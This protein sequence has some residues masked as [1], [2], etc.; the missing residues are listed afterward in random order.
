[1][2]RICFLFLLSVGLVLSSCKNY[3]DRFDA[4]NG[5]I[6]ALQGQV[7]GLSALQTE[8]TALKSTITAIQSSLSGLQGTVTTV[9]SEVT[10]A[11]QTTQSEVTTAL[12]TAQTEITK[13]VGDQLNTGLSGLS[14]KNE[15]L[16]KSLAELLPKVTALETKL[17][18][19]QDG[20][21]SKDELTKLQT[22]LAEQYAVIKGQ[23]DESLRNS[24]F[25]NDSLIID[26]VGRLKFATNVLFENITEINGDVTIDTTEFWEVAGSTEEETNKRRQDLKDF[27][28][29][30]NL[31]YGT[32]DITHSSE[33]L[34]DAIKF[35]N[36]TLVTKLVDK[37]PHVHYP[38]LAS[39]NE[40]TFAEGDD[41]NTNADNVLTVQI[42]EITTAMFTA[43]TIH[44]K[45]GQKLHLNN[46]VSHKGN[47]SITLNGDGTTNLKSL[48]KLTGGGEATLKLTGF[49][50][51]D[52]PALTTLKK[53]HVKDVNSLTAVNVAGDADPNKNGTELRISEDVSRVDVGTKGAIANL[54][55]DDGE[56]ERDLEHLK[57]G[58]STSWLEVTI[59]SGVEVAHIHGAKIVKTD[60]S[61]DLDTFI[62]AREIKE[63]TL[64][65]TDI[66]TLELG[67]TS[68]S[69]GKLEIVNNESLESLTADKVN[70][71]KTLKIQG[72]TRLETISFTDDDGNGLVTAASDAVVHIGGVGN[73][74]R[75]RAS[76]IHLEVKTGAGKQDGKIVDESGLSD[77]K[78]FLGSS[79]I[80]TAEV[81]YDGTGELKEDKND[82]QNNV[83]ISADNIEDLVL[84]RKGVDPTEPKKPAVKAKRVWVVYG[85][86]D[87]A[88]PNNIR[89]NLTGGFYKDITILGGESSRNI[90]AKI[91]G[92]DLKKFFSQNDVTID[93][94][95][96]GFQPGGSI[97]F[98]PET[99]TAGFST[100]AITDALLGELEDGAYIKLGIGGTEAKPEYSHTVYIK[101]DK[102]TTKTFSATEKHAVSH[103]LLKTGNDDADGP[104]DVADNADDGA[105]INALDIINRLVYGFPG[106]PLGEDHPTATAATTS[107]TKRDVPLRTI[108]YQVTFDNTN[109]IV[110]LNVARYDPSPVSK[111]IPLYFDTNVDQENLV[112]IG[113]QQYSTSKLVNIVNIVNRDGL[114][115]VN[116]GTGNTL[117]ISLTSTKVGDGDD[118]NGKQSTIG[119][120][121]SFDADLTLI[122]HGQTLGNDAADPYSLGLFGNVGNRHVGTYTGDAGEPSPNVVFGDNSSQTFGAIEIAIKAEKTPGSDINRFYPYW[123]DP[124]DNKSETKLVPV[125]GVD[126]KDAVNVNTENVEERL[127]WL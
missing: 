14:E 40:I 84:F 76:A 124:K 80:K 16:S 96:S 48:K 97:A 13:N 11:L 65:G 112:G 51:V 127:G 103:L 34:E 77:L 94:T 86:G 8:V 88:A 1:M 93:A 4:L 3:D 120:P 19:I 26:S 32:L 85:I 22:D 122:Q 79:N 9:Q 53:L 62:T 28:K 37:Q 74:N 71:L 63:L 44:L 106:R 109:G 36:L 114:G 119:Q 115:S 90:A 125:N 33:E 29:R 75:L 100:T 117:I 47:L 39:V 126:G 81:Y 59:P 116:N 61:D 30:I 35:E 68:G 92:E 24:N 69:G 123:H 45:K 21:V 55:I 46:F 54:K 41:T 57:I 83:D 56:A 66:E 5:Q 105:E 17:Q 6:T 43:G 7:T 89:V 64:T 110:A 102:P 101:G 78:S 108:P 107:A 2:K 104:D 49:S 111:P 113:F 27:A 20:A 38:A 10:T 87:T 73:E 91:K 15:A 52:L 12:E 60:G 70:N 50:S 23:L 95:A 42:P 121:I 72:N 98:T 25:H 58:G 118:D 67:H 82:E 99:G 31:I 18:S